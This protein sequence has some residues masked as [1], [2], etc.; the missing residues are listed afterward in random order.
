M[1]QPNEGEYDLLSSHVNDLD[2]LRTGRDMTTGQRTRSFHRVRGVRILSLK[3]TWQIEAVTMQK[4]SGAA[5]ANFAQV[6]NDSGGLILSAKAKEKRNSNG[7][8]RF[9]D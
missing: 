7:R 6:I 4:I 5:L 2:H 8:N 9:L 3:T 1:P